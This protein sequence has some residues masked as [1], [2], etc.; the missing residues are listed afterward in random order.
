MKQFVL[1]II[2]LSLLG[3]ACDQTTKD[4]ENE[5]PSSD[6]LAQDSLDAAAEPTIPSDYVL[7]MPL[8]GNVLDE[9]G[10]DAS[11]HGAIAT[12]N[13]HKEAQKAMK[14]EGNTY[15]EVP[16][17]INPD[18]FPELTITVWARSTQIELDEEVMQIV[19]H[20]DGEF[21]R[22]LGIDYRGGGTGWSAATKEGILGYS[23]VRY[24]HWTFLAVTYN[25]AK[26]RT[27]LHVGDKIFESKSTSGNGWDYL[28]IGANPTFGEY[29]VGDIDDLRIYNRVLS[30]KELE[31]LRNE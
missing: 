13:R 26:E 2:C 17:N 10:A 9:K 3:I 12:S 19:S 15:I 28:H 21:D 5:P 29:F 8:D 31:A 30:E 24:E 7:Y 27:V 14:F 11:N 20:D 22:S 16:L 25:Q 18:T 4:D 6:S 23:A 1:A